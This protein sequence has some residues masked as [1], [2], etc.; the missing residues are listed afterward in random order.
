[1]QVVLKRNRWS[2]KLNA[3]AQERGEDSYSMYCVWTVA[4][5]GGDSIAARVTFFPH[6]F[7]VHLEPCTL[8]LLS[9][10]GEHWTCSWSLVVEKVNF[11]C[12][13]KLNFSD[14]DQVTAAVVCGCVISYFRAFT[15]LSVRIVVF[16]IFS[17]CFCIF[18]HSFLQKIYFSSFHL[19]FLITHF[20]KLISQWTH[21]IAILLQS[22]VNL[23]PFC[24]NLNVTAQVNPRK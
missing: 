24:D 17:C 3:N 21:E 14:T 11:C 7:V 20:C 4:H 9:A 18:I 8:S 5:W 2:P 12:T 6:L 10:W 19:L 15:F 16:K 1:M 22:W 23:L 13:H